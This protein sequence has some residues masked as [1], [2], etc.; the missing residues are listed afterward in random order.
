MSSAIHKRLPPFRSRET[1]IGARDQPGHRT[2]EFAIFLASQGLALASSVKMLLLLPS[3]SGNRNKRQEIAS[4]QHVLPPCSLAKFQ[5][6]ST[7][8]H[9]FL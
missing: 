2:F 1:I 9:F 5:Q 6:Y 4:G 3:V 7:D 8:R